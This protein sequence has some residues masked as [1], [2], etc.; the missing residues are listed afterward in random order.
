MEVDARDHS[1][2][3]SVDRRVEEARLEE[4]LSATSDT[5]GNLAAAHEH[6]K[7]LEAELSHARRVLK[8]SDERAAAAEVRCEEVLKQ[9]S[10]TVDALR[11]RDEA[12]SQKEEI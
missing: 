4:N 9:L 2:R 11:E 7:S 8:E 5:R 6:A 3:E 12:V 10:S 1:L